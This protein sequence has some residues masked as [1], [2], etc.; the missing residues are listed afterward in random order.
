MTRWSHL[1]VKEGAALSAHIKQYAL[2]SAGF[3]QHKVQSW[4]RGIQH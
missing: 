3:E 1:Q 2:C 4:A